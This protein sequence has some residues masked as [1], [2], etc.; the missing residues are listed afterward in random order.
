M[1]L[2]V[3]VELVEFLH[4]GFAGDGCLDTGTE[5]LKVHTYS[6]ES[7]N[8]PAVGTLN[9]CYCGHPLHYG[10]EMSAAM[11]MKKGRSLAAPFHCGG[12]ESPALL[13]TDRVRHVRR[14]GNRHRRN[15]S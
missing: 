7:N 15:L 1:G 13:S 9:S 2:H 12:F 4:A 5:F 14:R 3:R 8:A 6:I 10:V 11:E